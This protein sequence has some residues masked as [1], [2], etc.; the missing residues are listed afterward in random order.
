MRGVWRFEDLVA[1]Q[2]AVQL[3]QLVDRYSERP[4]IKRVFKFREQLIDAAASGPRNIAEGFGRYHH[5]EFSRF[6]RIA[7]ASEEEV[8]N[9]FLRAQR[10][11][12]IS[13]AECDDG[14]HAARK[15]LKAVN[16][17]IRYLDSTPDFGKN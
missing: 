17:L 7:R 4:A 1:W 6:A 10:K 16:G 9:H 2:L 8:L 5:P 3:E 12:Y 11:G 14:T 13:I 15:P